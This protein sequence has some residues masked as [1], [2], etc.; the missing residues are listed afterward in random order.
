MAK[1]T[2]YVIGESFK[3]I[4]Q[5]KPLNKITVTEIVSDCGVNRMTFY[6]HFKDIYDLLEWVCVEDAKK[7]LE[8]IDKYENWQEGLL[9]L[10]DNIRKNKSLVMNAYHSMS[11]DYIEM[12]IY[13]LTDNLFLDVVGEMDVDRV[14][15]DKDK[16]F[17]ASFYKYALLGIML[18]WIEGDM[19]EDPE[20]IVK[21][22]TILVGNDL[23]GA[24]KRFSEAADSDG[25]GKSSSGR[26]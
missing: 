7:T 9:K 11:R 12:Y 19:K 14:L 21:R 4:L 13:R 17:I 24:I 26:S 23:G 10:F 2:K 6:Y 25:I 18:N 8:G 1:N 15:S 16:E 20:K 22:I 5:R 3:K